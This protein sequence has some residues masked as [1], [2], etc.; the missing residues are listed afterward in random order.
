MSQCLSVSL[1]TE[2]WRIRIK[3][4]NS[5][6]LIKFTIISINLTVEVSHMMFWHIRSPFWKTFWNKLTAHSVAKQKTDLAHTSNQKEESY[7]TTYCFVST[8]IS[9]ADTKTII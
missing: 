3:G 2:N 7:Q 9:I 8:V 5:K 4:L 1:L 6:Y